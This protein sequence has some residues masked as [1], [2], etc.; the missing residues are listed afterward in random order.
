MKAS[1]RQEVARCLRRK[2]LRGAAPEQEVVNAVDR[3]IGD[4]GQR[5]TLPGPGVNTV[6]FSSDDQ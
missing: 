6:K 2:R 1:R 4:I 3:M 5:M